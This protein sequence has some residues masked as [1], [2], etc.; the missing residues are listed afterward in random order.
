MSHIQIITFVYNNEKLPRNSSDWKNHVR[1]LESENPEFSE[2]EF[3]EINNEFKSEWEYED[4]SVSPIYEITSKYFVYYFH[5]NYISHVIF[6]KTEKEAE[7]LFW[8]EVKEYNDTVFEN[9]F[10][11]IFKYT[12]EGYSEIKASQY[13]SS[14]YV[15]FTPDKNRAVG[16]I[17]LD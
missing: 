16:L 7:D 14:P 2:E 5:E 17:K 4:L 11:G 12:F 15:I 8:K 10:V 1:I 6:C 9:E 13:D 3:E